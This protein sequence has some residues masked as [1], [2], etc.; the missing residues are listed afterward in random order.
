MFAII[1][2]VSAITLFSCSKSSNSTNPLAG[3]YNFIKYK[4]YFTQYGNTYSDSITGNFG[5]IDFRND[6]HAYSAVKMD[7]TCC[8]ITF[9]TTAVEIRYDTV[10]Y[11]INGN[12]IYVSNNNNIIL[13]S[14]TVINNH[15]EIKDSSY[16]PNSAPNVRATWAY[17][18][19]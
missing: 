16:H 19:K 8:K 13:D 12:V 10:K 4:G 6:G 1:V 15:F 14:V 2:G 5:Y 18:S 9:D 17:Y 3:K 11:R 7:L